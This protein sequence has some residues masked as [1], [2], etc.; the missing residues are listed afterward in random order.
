MSL[1]KTQEMG[2][3]CKMPQFEAKVC[4]QTGLTSLNLEPRLELGW[5]CAELQY[6]SQ[7]C[8]KSYCS[9]INYYF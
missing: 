8:S 5:L 7:C 3:L 4:S 9:C 1:I 6:M 2:M